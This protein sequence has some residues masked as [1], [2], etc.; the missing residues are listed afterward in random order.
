[1]LRF[2]GG[3][4]LQFLSRPPNMAAMIEIRL[5]GRFSVRRRGEEVAL[6]AFGGRLA[7]K[8][9]RVLVTRR[10]AFVS[11][12]ALADA[13]WPERPPADPDANINVL[14]NRARRALGDQT[15]ILTGPGG[16]S[17]AADDRI[18]VDAERFLATVDAGRRA[19]GASQPE[20][21][22]REF[23]RGLRLWGGDPLPEDAYDDWAAEFQTRLIRA[24]L[25]LLEQG[26]L[27]A[28]ESGD[29]VEAVE[30]AALAASR[31]PL[32]ERTRLLLV[33]G[34]AASGDTAAALAAFSAFR[35][36]YAEELGLDPS[37]EALEMES[38]ILQG[39]ALAPPPRMPGVPA[40]V[41]A[42]APGML[43]LPFVG[44]DE[45][46]SQILAAV[47]G[48]GKGTVLVSGVAGSG[49]SRLLAELTARTLA[50]VLG[51]RALLPEQEEPW[52]LARSLLR[53]ALA[54]DIAAVRDLPSRSA[55]ALADILPEIEELRSLP[56]APVDSES[57]RA[58][59]LEGAVR[60]VGAVSADGV[61]VAADDLQWSD[62]TSLQLLSLIV[63]R[64]PVVS[65]IVAYR[66]EE[67]AADGPVARF[68]AGASA[69]PAVMLVALGALPAPAFSRIFTD[70][71]VA[72]AVA[73]ATDGTPFAVAEVLRT[74]AAAGAV[75]AAAHGRWRA[76]SPDAPRL[77]REAALAGQRRALEGRLGRQPP[78]LRQLLALMALLGRPASARLLARALGA[79]A[80]VIL[81]DLDALARAALV[82]IDDAGWVPAHDL[83]A[84]T[85]AGSLQPAER[86]RLS[87][88]LAAT[89]QEEH[90]DPSEIARHLTAAGDYP[91][92]ARAL[93]EAAGQRLE[94]HASSEAERL[95]AQSLSLDPEPGLRCRLHEVRAEARARRGDLGGARGDL[96]EALGARAGGPDRSRLLARLAMLDFGSEDPVPA[97][98]LAELALVEA[99]SDP[100][101]RGNALFVGAIL[102]MNTRRG[103]RAEARFDEALRLFRQT[104]NAR[105]IADV[106]DGR[107]MAA[108]LGARLEEAAESFDRVA[109]LFLDSGNLLRV[110]TPRAS[111]GLALTWMASPREALADV[112]QALEL[113]R[114]LGHPEGEAYALWCR[115][116][117]LA[118]LHRPREAA[119]TA[120]A[121]LALAERLGHGEWTAAALRGLGIAR[122]AGGDPAGA[123]E[124]FRRSL[125]VSVHHHLPHFECFAAARLASVLI[126]AGSL[127]E[128]YGLVAN[129]LET[130]LPL[131]L[132]EARLAGAQLAV[133]GRE[134]GAQ[135]IVEEALRLAEQA[136]H[137][138]SAIS[139]RSLLAQC[140]HA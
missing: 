124:A 23:R 6:P 7:R 103:T 67:V 94:R 132:C 60:L 125:E 35:K 111:R 80:R 54:L 24:H 108:L 105:G 17:L 36:E 13:L 57:R 2:P 101:A 133:A 122:H 76:R 15:L 32:R 110:I 79:G 102:D 90:S 72:R 95:A 139:L 56:P 8:L 26:A 88:L 97:S 114:S 100:G 98:E 65:L 128:A 18:Q 131:S 137:R 78:A 43:E 58:L 91:A 117:A 109:R 126:E 44:R 3:P 28:L 81:S 138:A 4:A 93:A 33:R 21:A 112:D 92:A 70:A 42:V 10:G 62:A 30:M 127:T 134:R 53:S 27:A 75:E 118:A 63:E 38:A 77:A 106:L 119:E 11:R 12:D 40:R 69:S 29:P 74:L 19:L 5:L 16:Y 86:G 135:R 115:S 39:Q 104:G 66:P 14:V 83:I 37:R 47:E 46:L 140:G 9:V 20:A 87:A 50:P 113:A 136:A 107:A 73:A 31:E 85:V 52:S 49:K 45:E 25:E 84:D 89:L 55:Q 1:M 22:L 48:A 59:A 96:R 99:G 41:S 61:V 123:E 34:L 68:L 82:R 51:A 71:E 116:E 121:A 130:G 64:V 120:E 129:A